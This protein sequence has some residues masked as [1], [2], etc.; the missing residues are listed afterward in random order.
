MD[1]D[2]QQISQWVGRTACAPDGSKIGRIEDI[3]LDEETRKPE[4]LAV[5][6][7]LFGSRTS[8]VP[9]TGA[10]AQGDD[11]V[12]QY[13]KD[14]VKGAPN[15]EADGA[16]SQDEEAELYSHYGLNYSES[17]SDSGLPEGG[18][19]GTEGAGTRGR[20]GKS[21]DA[22]TRSEEELRIKKSTQEAGRVRLRKWVETE[23]VQ[24]SVPV[25]KE[26]VTVEREAIDS[27]N[28]D[29]AM[30]GAQISEGVHEVVLNEETA[31]ADTEVVPKERIRLDK[32][33]VTEQEQ[34]AADLRKERVEVEGDT[35]T[36]RRG[37]G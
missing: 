11:V 31:Y 15:A 9:I 22:M 27:S 6:T 21:D 7:G 25:T 17:R 2:T 32:E 1:V 36:G 10:S 23:H 19:A 4:W 5:A 16:L 37:N 14:Q 12:L 8:F 24:Q 29:S 30:S 13:T 26:R 28:V 18:Y 20:S 33:R 35:T 3:Y 34:I